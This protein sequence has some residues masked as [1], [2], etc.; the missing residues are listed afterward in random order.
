VTAASAGAGGTAR[1][2]DAQP[3]ADTVDEL[4]TGLIA[5][6]DLAS[7][8][9]PEGSEG[10]VAVQVQLERTL[11]GAG[12]ERLLV[13]EGDL[14]DPAF[15]MVAATEPAPRPGLDRRVAREVRA[16]WTSANGVIR[17][18]EVVVWTG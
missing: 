12:V 13:A 5:A 11:R 3:C 1:P 15:H 2:L 6:H 7:A 17:P 8:A 4:V 9:G 10:G 14:F 18:A 16:G